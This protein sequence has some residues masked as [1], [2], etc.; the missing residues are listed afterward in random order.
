MIP[1]RGPKDTPPGRTIAVPVARFEGRLALAMGELQSA[2]AGQRA[3]AD[4][5]AGLV[6]ELG[7][8]ASPDALRHIAIGLSANATRAALT[9]LNVRGAADAIAT[10]AGVLE[11]TVQP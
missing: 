11:G 3:I 6:N 8:K 1:P 4:A 2:A 7:T 10:V 5:L 9:A